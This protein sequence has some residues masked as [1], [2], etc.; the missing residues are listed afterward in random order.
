M[1]ATGRSPAWRP[2]Q[3]LGRDSRAGVRCLRSPVG[4]AARWRLR[5][6]ED[7]ALRAARHH[8]PHRRRR[9][10]RTALPRA[11]S[12]CSLRSLNSPRSARRLVDHLVRPSLLRDSALGVADDAGK[13]DASGRA[14]GSAAFGQPCAARQP[15]LRGTLMSVPHLPSARMDNRR[16]VRD[17]HDEATSTTGLWLIPVWLP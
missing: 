12:R 5:V 9:L 14:R 17:A 16:C 4:T 1:A 13:R 2:A 3:P 10:R 6:A 7:L 15:S 11:R 8:R